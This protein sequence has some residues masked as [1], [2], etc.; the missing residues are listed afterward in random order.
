MSFKDLEFANKGGNAEW[1]SQAISDLDRSWDV[2]AKVTLSVFSVLVAVTPSCHRHLAKEVIDGM[3]G[4]FRV[5]TDFDNDHDLDLLI[6]ETVRVDL[7]GQNLFEYLDPFGK[8]V[9]TE[10]LANLPFKWK[11]H[12]VKFDQFVDKC[13]K[14]TFFNSSVS[15]SLKEQSRITHVLCDMCSNLYSD[16]LVMSREVKLATNWVESVREYVGSFPVG[17]TDSDVLDKVINKYS[18]PDVCIL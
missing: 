4:I 9:V 8:A 10:L 16:D 18:F 3:V 15:Q 13:N 14:I 1:I 17:L 11:D 7:E 2:T 6:Q 5:L 12:I